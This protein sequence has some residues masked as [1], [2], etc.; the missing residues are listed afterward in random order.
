MVAGIIVCDVEDGKWIAPKF[1]AALKR[2]FN[3]QNKGTWILK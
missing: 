3:R 1:E 2:T